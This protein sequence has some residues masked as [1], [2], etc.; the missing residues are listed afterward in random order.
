MM[1]NTMY[2][3]CVYS[4]S[5]KVPSQPTLMWSVKTVQRGKFGICWWVEDGDD[6]GVAHGVVGPSSDHKYYNLYLRH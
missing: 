4:G 3:L 5:L 1:A 2:V 6:Q